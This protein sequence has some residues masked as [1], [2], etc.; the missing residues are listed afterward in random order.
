MECSKVQDARPIS[1][2]S[3]GQ[4]CGEGGT[5]ATVEASVEIGFLTL[6]DPQFLHSR[7]RDKNDFHE[8]KMYALR[9]RRT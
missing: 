3:G 8:R 4:G 9:D 2:T 7:G 5:A 1:L 6:H